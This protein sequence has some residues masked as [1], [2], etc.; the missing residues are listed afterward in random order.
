MKL[1]RRIAA[2]S[3][4][5]S[6]VALAV[7]II[8]NCFNCQ[9]VSNLFLGLFSSGILI[10][11]TAVVTYFYERNQTVLSVYSGCNEFIETLNKNLRADNRI[12]MYTLK[13]NLEEMQKVYKKE[14]YF[15][16]CQLMSMKKCFPLTKIVFEIWES[17]R[18]IYLFVLNDHDIIVDFILGDIS[19]EELENYSFKYIGEESLKQIKNLQEALDKLAYHMNYF[20]IRKEK[21]REEGENNAD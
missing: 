20:N 15:Y 3:G 14:V 1:Q 6:L 16:I 5:L 13:D 11:A 9:F 18:K 2:W 19:Q 17:V 8:L 12:G 10:C 4:L 7:A 21:N